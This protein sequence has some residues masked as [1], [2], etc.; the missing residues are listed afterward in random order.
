MYS[1][2]MKRFLFFAAMAATLATGCDKHPH[3]VQTMPGELIR[4]TTSGLK[5]SVETKI[6]E[7]TSSSLESSGFYVSATTGTAPQEAT[8]IFSD[9]LFGKSGDFWTGG[10]LWAAE[11]PGYHFFAS[12]V[13]MSETQTISANTDTDVIV[14]YLPNPVFRETNTLTFKHIFARLHNVTI[15]IPSGYTV[16]DVDVRITPYTSGVFDIRTGYNQTNGTGWSNLVAGEFISISAADGSVKEND[17][18]LIPGEYSLYASWTVHKDDYSYTYNNVE[19]HVVLVGGKENN[20]TMTLYGHEAGELAVSFHLS[21]D[22]WSSEDVIA[23]RNTTPALYGEINGHTYVDLGLRRDGKKILFA[24]MNV[25]ASVVEENGDY[26]AWA[27]TSKRYTSISG[28]NQL[29]GGTN[30][31]FEWNNCYYHTGDSYTSGWSKYI[32]DGK[33]SFAISGVTDNKAVLESID[34][35][36]AENWG[37]GWRVP[38]ESDLAFLCSSN[39]TRT[40]TDDYNGTGKHGYIITG[41]GLFST[42]SMFLP[43][44][45]YCDGTVW[46]SFEDDGRYWSRSLNMGTLHTEP[47]PHEAWLLYFKNDHFSISGGNRKSGCSIR[48]VIEASE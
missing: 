48:P 3:D 32:P 40:R 42:A 46:W 36:A 2:I 22:P 20:V 1:G 41:Q 4:F 6:S 31:R 7:V 12:N 47:F 30:A 28:T 10:K 18:Y 34:D 27:E 33:E 17:I 15:E 13:E 43:A 35:V 45:S 19:Y 9:V 16:S 5:A 29:L 39:V 38:D 44:A 37:G 26:F 11:D 25:G 21:V 14:A 24:T 23:E 8:N